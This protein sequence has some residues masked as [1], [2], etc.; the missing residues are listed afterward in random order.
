MTKLQRSI[1]TAG[2][3][4][5]NGASFFPPWI[6]RIAG[7][8]EPQT[9]TRY[10][11][12]HWLFQA[13]A[14]FEDLGAAKDLATYGLD[15]PRLIFEWFLATLA[16]GGLLFATYPTIRKHEKETRHEFK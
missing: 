3:V 10:T 12:A 13:P 5:L 9:I 2:I 8:T 1:V 15:W 6:G 11:G 14:L 7:T 4:A 16:T